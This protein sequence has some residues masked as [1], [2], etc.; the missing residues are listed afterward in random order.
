[1]EHDNIRSPRSIKPS[2]TSTLSSTYSNNVLEE[3][4]RKVNI[5]DQ[6][7]QKEAC[8]KIFKFKKIEGNHILVYGKPLSRRFPFHCILG[9]DWI[10]SFVYVLC[11]ILHY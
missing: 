3:E 9:P 2:N 1:M 11:L 6:Y 7:P 8:E 5:V 4:Q 10:C